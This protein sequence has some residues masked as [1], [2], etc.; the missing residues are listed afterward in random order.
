[1]EEGTMRS[2]HK[3]L[4]TAANEHRTG[5]CGLLACIALA[6][7]W[8]AGAHAQSWS[9]KEGRNVGVL[10]PSESRKLPDGGTYL[11]G[12]SK[13]HVLTED[14]SYPV[15]GCSMDCRWTCKIAASGSEGTCLTLCVGVDKDGD[16]FSFRALGFA[17]GKYE[18]G[19]G[20]GKY[21]NATGG[22]T[23]EPLPTDDPALTGV[24]WRGTLQLRR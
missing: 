5:A 24:R 8:S 22:G 12:G 13:V 2:H 19:A 11:T 20:T 10:L 4:G 18:V 1:M 15:T 9:I 3:S 14:A 21:A 17:T 23:F 7:V 16:L 6:L